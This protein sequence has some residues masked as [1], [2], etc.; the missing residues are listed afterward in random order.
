M[1]NPAER[2][3]IGM[4]LGGTKVFGALVAA[5]GTLSEESYVEHAG[6]DAARAAAFSAEERALGR[7]YLTLVELAADLAKRARAS[8]REPVGIGVGAPGIVSPEAD[9]MAA[10]R[11][12]SPVMA[13][14]SAQLGW[15]NV[16]LAPLLEARVGIPVR[17]ENDVN[18]AAL[19]EHAFGAGRGH[20]SLFLMAIGTGIGGAVVIDGRL[21]RGK[22]FSAGEI[23]FMMPG[24]EYLSWADPDWGALEAVASGSAITSDGQKAA[25][26]A[27][28]A[29]ALRGEQLFSAAAQGAPWARAVLDR[30]VD[31]WTVALSAVQSILDPDLMVISGGVVSSASPY[32]PAIA[33]RLRRVM[34]FAPK[35]VASTLGYKAGVLGA[36]ALFTR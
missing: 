12:S 26:A 28:V 30:A 14:T 22:N 18:L 3:Y 19:G 33:E 2:V 9:A 25:A 8:G 32:L 34:P 4:D 31:M 5:D 10:G 27:G 23:G 16:P 6:V 15:K 24:R 13:V 36:P 11:P 35:V 7:S 29:G 17:V 1:M 20:D 21:W